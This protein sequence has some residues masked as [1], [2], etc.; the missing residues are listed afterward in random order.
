MPYSYGE[1]KLEIRDHI[2]DNF[3]NSTRILDVGP[4]S[5]SYG[6]LLKQHYP[7]LDAVEIFPHYIDQF[8]LQEFYRNIYIGD[9]LDF[10]VTNYDYIILGDVLEHIPVDKAISL[11]YKF[12]NAGKKVLVAVPYK[13]IQGEEFG[14]IYE[15]HHQ[16]DLTIAIFY[17]RYPMFRL[18]YGDLKYGYFINYIPPIK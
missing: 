4:G 17:Q 10:D 8:N 7:Q 12:Y 1:Y 6:R 11:M 9:I 18:I 2:V 14:N 5:G 15:T 3:P 13:F 16:D